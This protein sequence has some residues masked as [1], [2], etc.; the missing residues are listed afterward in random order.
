MSYIVAFVVGRDKTGTCVSAPFAAFE[1]RLCDN[2][3]T[4]AG[5]GMSVSFH[6]FGE[7]ATQALVLGLV[8]S[9]ADEFMLFFWIRC[10]VK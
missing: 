8:I 2:E 3:V 10:E 9:G 4:V 6:L 7:Y 5:K 1:N